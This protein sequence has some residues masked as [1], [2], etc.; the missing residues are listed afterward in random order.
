MLVQANDRLER[1][2]QEN[3]MT[4]TETTIST[5]AFRS[6]VLVSLEEA[7][8]TVHGFFL[9]PGESTFNTLAG[10]SAA[11]A[12]QSLGPRSGN[13]AAKVNHVR[14]YMDAVLANAEAGDYIPVDWESSWAIGEVNDAEW[15]D[16]IDRLKSTVERFTN[17]AKTNTLWNEQTIGG[18]FGVVAHSAYHLGE[19]RQALAAIDP[20]PATS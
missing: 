15:Q 3:I 16:L 1:C 12:S 14:F 8:S 10:I 18:A 20:E 9:D 5:E 11:Q 13:I 17:L 6:A 7:F 4:T 19:I 2:T